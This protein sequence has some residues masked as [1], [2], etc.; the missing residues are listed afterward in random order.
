MSHLLA[1]TPI[2]ECLVR[3][4]FLTG[5]DSPAAM[6]EYEPGYIFGFCARPGRVPAFQVMLHCGA[7]WAHVPLHMV[8][9]KEWQP[10]DLKLLT[11]WDCF[12]A[13]FEIVTLELLRGVQVELRDRVGTKHWG[14][15]LFT[16]EWRGAWADI[17][18]Q[19]KNHHVIEGKN[20]HIFAY[21]NNKL[22][23]IDASY[24]VPM[25]GSSKHWKSNTRQWSVE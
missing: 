22:R 24:N 13:D 19:H 17:P 20:G 11:W 5:I 8:C 16:V 6:T 18:D 23:W 1:S 21:P 14:R 4:S 7:Q 9:T 3:R 15:Y 2:I 25:P 12:S 10:L